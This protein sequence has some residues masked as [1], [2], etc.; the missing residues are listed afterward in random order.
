ML[1][2][3]ESLLYKLGIKQDKYVPE[4]ITEEDMERF[5]YE[6]NNGIDSEFFY[7][8]EYLSEDYM[9]E[10]TGVRFQ[11]CSMPINFSFRFGMNGGVGGCLNG[12]R[13]KVSAE[14]AK[15]PHMNGTLE[16]FGDYKFTYFDGEEGS[17]S[18]ELLE[19]MKTFF[20]KYKVLFAAVWEW[21]LYQGYLADYFKS[22]LSFEEL[23]RNFENMSLRNR[24][25]I[26]K[27][28]DIKDLEKIVREN[29]I[30]NMND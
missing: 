7:F 26:R 29:N 24:R 15:V 13:V 6:L 23:V 4:E 28:T 17:V 10:T 22:R 8:H 12:I 2:H 20:K 11:D 1:R 18:E 16:I 21:K 30:F 3:I 5:Y 9:M 25:L 27:A 14:K 19:E